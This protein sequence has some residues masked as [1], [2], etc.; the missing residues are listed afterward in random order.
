MFKLKTMSVATIING[1][2]LQAFPLE[3]RCLLHPFYS[4]FLLAVLSSAVRREKKMKDVRFRKSNERCKI[5]KRNKNH[6]SK[7][8]ATVN[9]YKRKAKCSTTMLSKLFQKM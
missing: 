6:L 8:G 2:I 5:L 1:K 7:W 4:T 9:T 3:I